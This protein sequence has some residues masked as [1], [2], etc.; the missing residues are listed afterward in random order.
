MNAKKIVFL[1]IIL[2]I[3][4]LAVAI[5][6]DIALKELRG[7]TRIK[8]PGVYSKAFQ[9]PEVLL[10]QEY[11]DHPELIL[12]QANNKKK[13]YILNK[14]AR[15]SWKRSYDQSILYGNQALEVSRNAH[16]DFGIVIS[17]IT[18]AETFLQMEEY[19]KASEKYLEAESVILKLRDKKELLEIYDGLTKVWIIAKN[20][21]KALEYAIKSYELHLYEDNI[22]SVADQLIRIGNVYFKFEDYEKALDYYYQALDIED[23]NQ[24]V[25]RQGLIRH[26]LSMAYYKLGDF[27]E[28]QKNINLL[29]ENADQVKNKWELA[30]GLSFRGYLQGKMEKYDLALQD[31]AAAMKIYN[32]IKDFSSQVEISIGIGN[33]QL[34]SGKIRQANETY[35][36]ARDMANKYNH[37]T[38]LA[39]LENNLAVIA[40]INQDYDIA[41]KKNITSLNLEKSDE[42]S[43]GI[44]TS[45]Y[46][47]GNLYLTLSK[48]DNSVSSF[49]QSLEIS[50]GLGEDFLIKEIYFRLAELYAET[51][52]YKKALD[53]H[54]K[55][56]ELNYELN[57]ADLQTRFEVGKKRY[58]VELLKK[59]NT[60]LNLQKSRMWIGMIS[61]V[62]M[63]IVMIWVNA[64]KSKVNK[65]LKIEV[66][67][68]SRT[69]NE[70]KKIKS[71]LEQR[72]TLR[73]SELT[74]LNESLQKEVSDRRQYQEKLELS[75]EEKDV[76]MK[77]IH[78]R[79]KN[80]MQVISSLLKMQANYIDDETI[81]GIFDDSYHR[82][83][84]MSL[85]HEKL[86]RSND[87]ARIDFQD[88]VKSL[89]S[90]LMNTFTPPCQIDFEFDLKNI[91]LDVNI[92]IPCGLII[93]EI[94][95]NSLKYA[96]A[97]KT[98]GKVVIQMTHDLFS[99]YILKIKDN[100]I[101]LPDDF[102]V[103]KTR[104]LGMRLVYL[105]SED[106][107]EGKV[108]I[109]SDHGTEFTITFPGIST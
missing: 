35:L 2:M 1:I 39:A 32:E 28:A 86:Y 25:W 27:A 47:L 104:S 93:N 49:L 37:V 53:A 62:I 5:N 46:N 76:M 22:K 84:S 72:V 63:V 79:V 102:D 44:I 38:G 77:E 13:M 7:T 96:F 75:L 106:Q 67:E 16:L 58:E 66:H 21:E 19:E 24:L 33:V 30:D 56:S 10:P 50:L 70:L 105:L 107:L 34:L 87:L 82:V 101:G 57:I 99:G 98:H 48:Y 89:T 65:T 9:I 69:E 6:L 59:Q 78:H 73:T 3:T 29:L 100:G 17:L 55:Y 14:L 60:I 12:D 94:I 40:E 74:R 68:R 18:L 45:L 51:G 80:N 109:V 31:Y 85:I 4:G 64:S 26:N 97:N 20:K 88:Y 54:K 15:D 92:A 108:D 81:V 95:T 91:L 36:Q 43:I 23:A 103:N 71:E 8:E 90:L 11:I 61:L 83:K 42:N 41:I 52:E